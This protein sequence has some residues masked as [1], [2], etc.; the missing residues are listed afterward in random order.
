ML[1]TLYVHIYIY[2]LYMCIYTYIMYIRTFKYHVLNQSYLHMKFDP[3]FDLIFQ[4]FITN[5]IINV[6]E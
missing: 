6:F 1:H 4:C 3:R 2:L 5:I